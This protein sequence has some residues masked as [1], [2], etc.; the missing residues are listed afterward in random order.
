MLL[1]YAGPVAVAAA[2]LSCSSERS[3]G[4]SGTVASIA[5]S[6]TAATLIRTATLQF[7]ATPRDGAGNAVTGQTV[8]WTTSTPAVATVSAT[9]AVTAVGNGTDTVTASAGG[10]SAVATI[11][12]I[13]VAIVLDSATQLF[14]V[15]QADALGMA[16][17]PDMHTA[18][19]QQPDGSYRLWI[20]GRFENDTVEGATGLLTTRVFLSYAAVGST[21]DAQPVLTPSCRP[22]AVA[23]ET[24]FDGVYAG[25]DWVW[26]ASN[27]TDLLMLYHGGSKYYG[28]GVESDSNPGWGTIGL[29]RS[30]D[31]GVTWTGRTAVISGTDAKPSTVPPT[32]I[33][34][35]VEPGIIAAG[36]YLYAYYAYFPLSGPSQIQVARAPSSG[37]GA[38]GTWSKYDDGFG[39]QPG[40]GGVG[41]PVISTAGT[42]CTRPAQPWPVRSTYL[43]AYVLV[44]LC[45]EGWFFSTST[46]LVAWTVPI[47]FFVEPGEE[48]QG[49]T[50]E[51]VILVTPGNPAQSVGQTGY[52]L[53]AHT[54]NWGSVAHQL[55]MRPFTFKMTP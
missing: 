26:P 11:T 39:T 14:Q 22:F 34:G 35:A 10:R 5:L 42:G 23:C 43:N 40:L 32:G 41:S 19:L 37:D 29:A 4:P 36:G 33:Y 54:P 3:A 6:Q 48:F 49:P 27:G 47:Q 2:C 28:G 7:A 12:V 53:Y 38:A 17:V 9:G 16:G 25:A 46:D 50:D 18:I 31:Q 55:Y 1:R 45:Q 44:F 52:A 8:V 13:S 20:A 21:T 15:H 24:A 51:N 30:S